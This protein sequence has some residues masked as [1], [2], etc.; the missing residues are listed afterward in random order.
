MNENQLSITT[1]EKQLLSKE[2]INLPPKQ[3]LKLLLN[4]KSYPIVRKRTSAEGQLKEMI[5]FYNLCCVMLAQ[6]FPSEEAED[7]FIK[8]SFIASQEDTQST[9]TGKLTEAFKMLKSYEELE[10]KVT[11]IQMLFYQY[12]YSYPDLYQSYNLEDL[13]TERA[14]DRIRNIRELIKEDSNLIEE[15]LKRWDLL[16]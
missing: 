8:L 9:I 13:A 10:R 12:Y 16:T 11:A 14:I 6:Y 5:A 15:V 3:R 7:N 4:A 1:E 2:A